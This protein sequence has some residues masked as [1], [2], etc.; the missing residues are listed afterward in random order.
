MGTQKKKKKILTHDIFLAGQQLQIFSI[1]HKKKL[2]NFQI[3]DQVVFWKWISNNTLALITA[4]SVY[5]WSK[6]GTGDPQKV[7]DR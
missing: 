2:K 4:T 3:A 1:E 7:F 6:E 5:H